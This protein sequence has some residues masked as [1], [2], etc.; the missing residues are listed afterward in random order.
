MRYD[1]LVFSHLKWDSVTQRPQHIMSRLSDNY[2]ILFIE[3]PDGPGG[4]HTEGSVAIT[5]INE[6]LTVL[7]PCLI[8]DSWK[9]MCQQYL[10]ILQQNVKG[11]TDSIV[12]FYSPFYVHV[13]DT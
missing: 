10:I 2:K 9:V 4:D 11:I 3:E 13:L 5:M 6:N 7:T 1:I 12:W 8:W